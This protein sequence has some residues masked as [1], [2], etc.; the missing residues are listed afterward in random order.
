MRKF[1]FTDGVQA[2]QPSRSSGSSFDIQRTQ[3][4]TDF[5]DV[6]TSSFSRIDEML[7][8]IIR[9]RYQ[10]VLSSDDP[11]ARLIGFQCWNQDEKR[12]FVSN[13]CN[14]EAFKRQYPLVDMTNALSR[15]VLAS[16]LRNSEFKTFQELYT[17][18]YCVKM[19][20]VKIS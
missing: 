10:K 18:F 1:D 4:A 7:D 5:L 20:G 19:G 3:T 2:P 13:L 9:Q 17:N 15:Q 14:H 12:R 8:A 11:R 16:V 6:T